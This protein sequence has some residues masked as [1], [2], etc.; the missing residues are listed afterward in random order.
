LKLAEEYLLQQKWGDAKLIEGW[1]REFQQTIEEVV[2]KV[3][4][5]AGPDPFKENWQAI[6]SSHLVEVHSEIE[7]SS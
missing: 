5:E 7:S 1:R 6:S 4:R 2:A 3:Q